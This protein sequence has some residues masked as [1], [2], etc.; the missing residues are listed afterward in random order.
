MLLNELI[1][2]DFNYYDYII[3]HKLNNLLNISEIP[4]NP[5]DKIFKSKNFSVDPQNFVPFPPE[6]DDLSR[7]HYIVLNR[8]VLSDIAISDP[9]TF[10]KIVKSISK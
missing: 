9:S 8:K 5:G 2:K 7:L 10:E 1:P 4:A 6:L 3:E